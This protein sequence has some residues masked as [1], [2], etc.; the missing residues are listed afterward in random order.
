MQRAPENG[1]VQNGEMKVAPVRKHCASEVLIDALRQ[2]SQE[3][4]LSLFLLLTLCYV[5]QDMTLAVSSAR[6]PES[7][8][9]P[10][11]SLNEKQQVG[12]PLNKIFG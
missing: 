7:E 2:C 9:K 1:N 10:Q 8:E 3:W 11:K 5:L 4:N 6:E 12:G